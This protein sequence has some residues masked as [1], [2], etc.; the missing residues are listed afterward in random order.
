MVFP[1][2]GIKT[3]FHEQKQVEEAFREGFIT[4][5]AM[6]TYYENERVWTMTNGSDVTGTTDAA[7]GVTDGGSTLSADTASP[8]TYTVGQVFTI[9]GVYA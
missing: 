9:A 7:A 4:R 8:V 3:L 5:N 2:D 1:E 6:A